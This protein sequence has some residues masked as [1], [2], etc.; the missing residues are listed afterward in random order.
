MTRRGTTAFTCQAG[1]KERGV[2]NNRNAGPVKCNGLV[3]PAVH[4]QHEPATTP[5]SIMLSDVQ[6]GDALFWRRLNKEMK[7]VRYPRSSLGL[8][9][10]L[11]TTSVLMRLDLA[12]AAFRSAS[13]TRRPLSSPITN[14][15]PLHFY[16]APTS[17][18]HHG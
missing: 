13:R 18:W 5:A 9:P 16:R 12:S 4:R 1:C 6:L 2:S 10:A 14:A 11:Y 7:A 17:Q 8:P 3:R 15:V